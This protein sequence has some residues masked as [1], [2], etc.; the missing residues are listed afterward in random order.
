MVGIREYMRWEEPD[1]S[2]L[3]DESDEGSAEDRL[4]R[5]KRKSREDEEYIELDFGDDSYA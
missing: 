2:L 5:R 1:P 3:D 4:R